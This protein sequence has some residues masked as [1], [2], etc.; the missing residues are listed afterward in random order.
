MP[1]RTL[2]LAPLQVLALGAL[3]VLLGRWLVARVAL[4]RRLN[5][6]SP[7]IGGLV[8]AFLNWALRDRV[9]TFAIDASL[10]EVAMMAFFTSVGFGARLSLVRRGGRDLVTFLGLAA[11]G[12]V[13]QNVVG[14]GLAR[15]FGLHPLLGVVTGSVA[16]TGGPGTALAFGTEFEKLNVA[17]A[18]AA[19]LATAILGVV[20]GG[21]L[22]GALGAALLERSPVV[23]GESDVA[24]PAVVEAAPEGGEALSSAVLALCLAMGLGTLVSKALAG[25]GMTLP[26]YVGAMVVA[27]GLRAFDDARPRQRLSGETLDWLGDIALELFIVMALLTLELWR[28]SA[29]ALP[30]LVM[31]VAQVVLVVGL[32]VLV[33]RVM[34]RSRESAVIAAGYCGFMLGTT[35]NAMAC[36]RQLTQRYGPAPRAW[37]VVPIVGAFLIDFVN[38]VLVTGLM[39]VLKGS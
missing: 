23:A 15:A 24:G 27:G 39:N 9:V 3:G 25:L 21:L 19:G 34:G 16:L 13:A 1:V 32:V 8:L 33:H 14:I 6:P 11:L 26:A 29:L 36:L 22:G 31:L 7:I 17:G 12:A 35:A 5:V 4:L 10:R 37:L 18:E 20:I 2:S 38:S 30:M 28:L